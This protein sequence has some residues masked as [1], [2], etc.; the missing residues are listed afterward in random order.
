MVMMHVESVCNYRKADWKTL[1]GKVGIVKS[2]DIYPEKQCKRK[3]TGID[4]DG[5]KDGRKEGPKEGEIK[6]DL[7]GE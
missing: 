2:C 4:K 7:R 5:E 6:G 3:K 1:I